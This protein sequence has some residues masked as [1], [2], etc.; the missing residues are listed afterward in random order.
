MAGAD[1]K[2]RNLKDLPQ[3]KRLQKIKA[4]KLKR[5]YARKK[6]PRN[7]KK[8][9]RPSKSCL[10]L[11]YLILIIVFLIV[12]LTVVAKTGMVDI[13][14]ISE[15]F[16]TQPV[17]TRKVKPTDEIPDF[18]KNLDLDSLNENIVLEIT[19]NQLTALLLITKSSFENVTIEEFQTAILE[20]EIEIFSHL[21]TPVDAYLVLNVKPKVE[22]NKIQIQVNKIKLGD[23]P[24]PAKVAEVA[25]NRLISSA[26]DRFE[27]IIDE[28]GS[29]EN[30][31]IQS[32]KIRL[33]IIN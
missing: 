19:E 14:V 3:Y 11:I 15:A 23:L 32:Q 12:I 6:G 4:K 1:L 30:I 5:E 20:D 9:S 24:L 7:Y 26:T 17:P 2:S 18:L 10:C 16:Y 27:D 28:F 31:D 21:S 22:D 29:V 13:P 33:K 8:R 25:L